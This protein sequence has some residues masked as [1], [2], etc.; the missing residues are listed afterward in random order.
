MSSHEAEE[1]NKLEEAQSLQMKAAG[2]ELV[3]SMLSLIP[4]FGLKA[5]P[6]GVG[7]SSGFGGAQLSKTLS[8]IASHVRFETDR[9]SYEASNTA[10]IGS[11]AHREQEWAYQSNLAAGEINQIYKQLRAAQIREAIAEQEWKNHRQQIRHAE[12][13]EHFL[14]GEKNTS[15]H[16][17]TPT[18]ALYTWMKREVK[19]LYA[20]E[21]LWL[22]LTWGKGE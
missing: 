10:K 15:G 16:R 9:L 6:V 22:A 18:Q 3:G 11:Y 1:M 19:G 21:D 8:L 13:I 4:Q 2:L 7:G 14:S 20:M 17:K 5:M 12:D